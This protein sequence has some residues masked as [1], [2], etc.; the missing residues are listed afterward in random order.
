MCSSYTYKS[1]GEPSSRAGLCCIIWNRKEDFYFRLPVPVL[2]GTSTQKAARNVICKK[3]RA[4]C[5]NHVYSYERKNDNKISN[6]FEVSISIL[7]YID[8]HVEVTIRGHHLPKMTSTVIRCLSVGRWRPLI[9]TSI[10][11]SMYR[12]STP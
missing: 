12:K 11:W 4:D 1:Y 9:V 3:V 10:C 2:R 6:H 5:Q 7:R 8:R